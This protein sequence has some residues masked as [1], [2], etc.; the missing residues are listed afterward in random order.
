VLAEILSIDELKQI[1]AMVRLKKGLN[2]IYH[3]ERKIIL[4]NKSSEIFLDLRRH[5]N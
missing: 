1:A 5:I 2:G 4:Y 3:H